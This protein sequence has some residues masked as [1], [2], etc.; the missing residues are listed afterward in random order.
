MTSDALFPRITPPATE[1]R[2]VE[3][4]RHGITRD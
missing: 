3:D 4:T 2:P 1:K